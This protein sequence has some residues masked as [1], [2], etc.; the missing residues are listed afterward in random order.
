MQMKILLLSISI[1][2]VGCKPQNNDVEKLDYEIIFEDGIFVEKFDTTN[3][4]EN[5]YTA[6]NQTYIEGSKRIYDYF[7][8]T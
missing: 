5:R 2:L 6:N 3:I 8:Q 1:L 4:S 7:Y